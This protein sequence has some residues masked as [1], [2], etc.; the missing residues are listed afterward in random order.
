[1]DQPIERPTAHPLTRS[2]LSR[3]G[4]LA[5]GG[6]L[7][8]AVTLA[9]CSQD[10]TTTTSAGSSDTSSSGSASADGPLTSLSDVPVGSAVVLEV[11]GGSSVVVA[12][13]TAGQVV[14]FSALCTHQGCAVAV[15]DAELDCPCHGSRF[16]AFT[17][18]VL[19][20]PAT[21]PLTP[22]AVTVD[23]E[24]VVADA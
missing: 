23:G 24:S 8:S 19:Q 6:A 4:A 18:A 12:Q 17:G 1:M 7:G 21:D 22:F 20:G 14:G 2:V 5:A 16:D 15:K 9:A 11:A 10:G 13:P 3:R